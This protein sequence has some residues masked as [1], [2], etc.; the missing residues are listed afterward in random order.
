[1]AELLAREA[2]QHEGIRQRALK[3]AARY[4]FLWPEHASDVL[5]AGRSLT[6]LKGVGPFIA[7]RL[8]GWLEKPPLL[9]PPPLR[10][11]F[12]TLA[13]ARSLLDGNPAWTK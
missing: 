6:E 8:S 10:R 12:L 1:M 7:Q 5:A 9:R 2:E 11:G 13:E 4:A 3:R